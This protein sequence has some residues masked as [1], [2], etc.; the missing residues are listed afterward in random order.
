VVST[1]VDPLAVAPAVAAEISSFDKQLTTDRIATMDAIVWRMQGPWR[2]NVLV[3]GLFGGVALV[4]SAVGLF[5][6]VGWDVAQRGREIGLRMAL[7]AA[8]GNVV[9]LM[10]WQGMKPAGLGMVAGLAVALLVTRMLSPFLFETIP[11]DLATFVGVAVLFA[12]VV[13]LASYL[14]ARRAA[15][16]DPLVV[17]KDG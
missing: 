1:R 16:I 5:A 9:R 13:V 4:L 17:L 14:P 3:F 15:A 2:F 8:Q 10:I 12:A 11:T 7:G 6:L